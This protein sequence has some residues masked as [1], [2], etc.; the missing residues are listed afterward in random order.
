MVNY[1]FGGLTGL[2][3]RIASSKLLVLKISHSWL[4]RAYKPKYKLA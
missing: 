1:K 4:I 3:K 2:G